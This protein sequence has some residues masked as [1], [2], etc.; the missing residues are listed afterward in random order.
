MDGSNALHLE[1]TNL[2]FDD[3]ST[4]PACA[5][6]LPGL[7]VGDGSVA[8]RLVVA[9]AGLVCS[10]VT[11]QV[12]TD[13]TLVLADA[14]RIIEMSSSTARTLTVPPGSGTGSVAFP[15]GTRID[16]VRYGTGAVTVIPGSG[17]T[18]RSNQGTV[19]AGQ[20]SVA[21]MYKHDTNEWVL[22]GDLVPA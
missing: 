7:Y 5:L 13:Y 15:K 3:A 8:P 19:L 1:A 4:H 16:V 22:V 6:A 11:S 10:E 9:S 12:D 2:Y 20:Y 14:G 18:I 17:V 21:S